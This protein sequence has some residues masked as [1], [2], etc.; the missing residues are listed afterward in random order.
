[1]LLQKYVC[2]YLFVSSFLTLLTTT[3]P[4]PNVSILQLLVSVPSTLRTEISLHIGQDIVS[5]VHAFFNKPLEV[6]VAICSALQPQVFFAGDCVIRAGDLGEYMFLVQRGHIVAYDI[7]GQII[8]TYGPGEHF[9]AEALGS[10]HPARFSYISVSTSNILALD[11]NS[12]S[13]I[14]AA[15]SEAM[16]SKGGVG[17]F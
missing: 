13:A 10:R 12:A 5:R 9:G 4:S 15:H 14:L 11:V 17:D 1:M 6:I 3:L 16:G 7:D 8:S 2:L